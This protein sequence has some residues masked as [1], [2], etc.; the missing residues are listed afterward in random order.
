M[1]THMPPRAYPWER[2]IQWRTQVRTLPHPDLLRDSQQKFR[3]IVY[4]RICDEELE[5]REVRDR[6]KAALLQVEKTYPNVSF[7]AVDDEV[8]TQAAQPHQISITLKIDPDGIAYV[9]H[10]SDCAFWVNEP[11]SCVTGKEPEKP[12]DNDPEIV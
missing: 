4:K 3:S 7:Y 5:R 8:R 1:K 10:A 9:P 11:C 2:A 6:L 12:L